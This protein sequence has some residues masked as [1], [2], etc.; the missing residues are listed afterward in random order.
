MAPRIARGVP[1][2]D[3]ATV[4]LVFGADTSRLP[5]RS[6]A[7]HIYH[8]LIVVIRGATDMV[9]HKVLE[10]DLSCHPHS[11]LLAQTVDSEQGKFTSEWRPV[12]PRTADAKADIGRWMIVSPSL[13]HMDVR[14]G[15]DGIIRWE[16]M[17][18]VNGDGSC[19]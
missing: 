15:P 8:N 12:C 11:K 4:L 18:E 3:R 13:T 6:R 14:P 7:A 9:E 2:D 5:S 16:W 10:V 17:A 19:A 1:V